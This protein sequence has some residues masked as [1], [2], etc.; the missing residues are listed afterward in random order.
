MFLRLYLVT[1]HTDHGC[2][3]ATCWSRKREGAGS[4][5]L[6]TLLF[7]F[8]FYLFLLDSLK[9]IFLLM[10]F[11]YCSFNSLLQQKMRRQF[12]LIPPRMLPQ[13][14]IKGMVLVNLDPLVLV[15]IVMSTYLQSMPLRHRLSITEVNLLGFILK[16]GQSGWTFYLQFPVE[17]LISGCIWGW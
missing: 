9:K 14:V 16:L 1:E 10:T 17:N 2:R 5:E 3:T 11:I 12:L 15:E 6:M 7:S 4:C 13:S 8:L